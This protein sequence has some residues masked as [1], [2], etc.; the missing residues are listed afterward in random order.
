VRRTERKRRV[1]VQ[2]VVLGLWVVWALAF[3]LGSGDLT[4][5]AFFALWGGVC[6]GFALFWRWADDTR[7]VLLRRRGYYS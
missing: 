3:S 1:T 7:R 4:M 6:G 2:S 5:L